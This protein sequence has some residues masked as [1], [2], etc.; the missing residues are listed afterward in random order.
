MHLLCRPF[1][2]WHYF[3]IETNEKDWKVWYE[4]EKP[5]AEEIPCSYSTT[6]DGFRKL[7]LIRSWSPDRT[8]SQAKKYIEG[9]FINTMC[10]TQIRLFSTKIYNYVGI[11]YKIESL[12]PEYSEMLILDLDVTW[13]ESEPRTPLVCI[14]SIGSDP[15]TQIATLA[16]NKNIGSYRFCIIMSGNN[17]LV[18]YTISAQ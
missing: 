12:G 9:K 8:I 5:E 2:D 10:Y 15:T 7:L 13:S 11:L 3:Q 18:N 14:L 17:P 4:S 16:K 1:H 6:L